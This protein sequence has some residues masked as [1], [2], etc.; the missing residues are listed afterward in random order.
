MSCTSHRVV[1]LHC[2]DTVRSSVIRDWTVRT[3]SQGAVGV[4][5]DTVVIV[6]A[7]VVT[8]A[9]HASRR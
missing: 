7:I 8:E 5:V 2:L 6:H 1:P 4:G 3:K 9:V